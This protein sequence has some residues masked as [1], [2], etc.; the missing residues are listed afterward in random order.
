MHS[1]WKIGLEAKRKEKRETL[2][3]RAAILIPLV[4]RTDFVT[5]FD[6]RTSIIRGDPSVLG[7]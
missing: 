2:R 3:R 4:N 6:I 7:R 1:L 5:R